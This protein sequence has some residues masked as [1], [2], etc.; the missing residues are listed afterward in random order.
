MD[1]GASGVLLP[2]FL[3]SLQY[4]SLSDVSWTFP[5]LRSEEGFF[6]VVRAEVEK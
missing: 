6:T 3:P 4:G 2:S 1:V 5:M